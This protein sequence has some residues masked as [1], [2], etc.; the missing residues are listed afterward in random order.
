MKLKH[1]LSVSLTL[2]TAL[3]LGISFLVATL[4]VKREETDDLDR[5]IL[6]QATLSAYLVMQRDHASPSVDDGSGEIPELPML[7][8]RYEAIYA[9]DGRLLSASRTFGGLA[10]RYEQFDLHEPLPHKGTLVELMVGDTP[11]RGVMLP[12]GED[13]RFRLLYALSRRPV[14]DDLRFLVEVFVVLF[15]SATGLT[16]VFSRWLG[17]RLSGD[18]DTI[19]NVARDVTSGNL[20]AR[21]R[22]RATGSLE[23]RALGADMDRMIGQ[24]GALMA[25]QRTFVSHAAHELRSPLATLRGELQLALRRPRSADE[26]RDTIAESLSEVELLIALAEDLLVLARLQS[27]TLRREATSTLDD[28][29]NDA[30]RMSRGLAEVQGVTFQLPASSPTA[31]LRG[32]RP[33][34]ARAIRNLLDNAVAHSPP[35]G[36]VVVDAALRDGVVILSISDQGPGVPPQDAPH[37]FSAFYRGSKDQSEDK[38]TGLGLA[39]VREILRGVGGRVYLDPDRSAGARFVLELP[40]A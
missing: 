3:V 6:V 23:L 37:I 2:V 29:L 7:A 34:L 1:R 28:V 22:G 31:P 16:A 10:P 8:R 36:A 33:D 11:L 17:A 24:L 39:I 19:A 4:L 14:D 30:L 15:L 27:D 21:V 9:P 40:T 12:F 35:G 32:A 25:T 26:Y 13:R 20:D 18:V 38:G 5:A